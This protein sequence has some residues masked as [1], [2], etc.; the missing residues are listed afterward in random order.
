MKLGIFDSGIGGEAVAQSLGTA[1]PEAAIM[2]VNDREHVPYGDRTIED[3]TQLTD[4]AIQPLLEAQCDVIIIACNSAT[5]AAIETLRERYPQQPFIGL[6]PMVKPATSL[7]KS[8]VVAIC[9]TPATLSSNRYQNLKQKYGNGTTILEPNCQQWARMIE[10]NDI[11]ESHIEK[12]IETVCT[13]GA[14]V[15]VLAC[16]H[17]HWIREV[18]EKTA[19]GRATVLDPS[20]AIARRVSQLL[21]RR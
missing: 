10:D 17:Y 4:T 1:F 8:G 7:T 11:N 18:I 3:I 6:E 13:Q 9:A 12:T 5:A 20:D 21:E 15:I 19:A 16:T 14:D 2:I